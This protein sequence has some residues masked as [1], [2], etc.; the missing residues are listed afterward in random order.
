MESNET[1]G[2]W[3][4]LK[5]LIGKVRSV[6][7]WTER[8][9]ACESLLDAARLV[10]LP[11]RE[12]AADKDPDIAH[13]GNQACDQIR[14]DFRQPTETMAGQMDSRLEDRIRR[15]AETGVSAEEPLQPDTR[16]PVNSVGAAEC[17]GSPDELV[18]WVEAVVGELKGEFKRTAAGCR[19][20]LPVS[21]GREQRI[22]LDMTRKNTSGRPVGLFYSLCGEASPDDYEWALGANANL[23]RGAF[24]VIE[25][26]DSRMMVL[27]LRRPFHEYPRQSLAKKFKYLASKA[28]WAESRLSE[29]DRH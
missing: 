2:F 26:K 12:A 14:Q 21:E 28:D 3:E 5:H 23:S 7:Y 20:V 8:R 9:D 16:E 11:L 25:H 27:M 29:T 4:G 19:F 24:A 13:W 15:A 17:A 22:Y 6:S 1:P 10:I 18:E